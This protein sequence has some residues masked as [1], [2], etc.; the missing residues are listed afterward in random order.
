MVVKEMGQGHG[1]HGNVSSALETK[2][3]YMW[4]DIM[5]MGCSG[6]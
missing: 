3:R 5:S 2:A 1:T 4:G 6:S